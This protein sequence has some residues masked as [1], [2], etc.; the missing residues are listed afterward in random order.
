MNIRPELRRKGVPVKLLKS[1]WNYIADKLWIDQAIQCGAVIDLGFLPRSDVPS[2]LAV[3]D[4]LVQPGRPDRFNEYRFP[5]KLPEFLVSGKPVVLPK[6]NLG[7][8]VRPDIEAVLLEYGD[9][10]EIAKQVEWLLDQPPHTQ[11]LRH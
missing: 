10:L 5:C 9:G 7:R 4:V 1:G 3:A 11:R 8:F 6:T 2:L